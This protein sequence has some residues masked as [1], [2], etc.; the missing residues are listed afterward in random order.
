MENSNEYPHF[1]CMTTSS[2]VELPRLHLMEICLQGGDKCTNFSEDACSNSLGME[3]E[4]IIFS[5]ETI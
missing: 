3:F 1:R 5:L 2:P 4:P